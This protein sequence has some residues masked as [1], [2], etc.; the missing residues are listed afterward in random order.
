MLNRIVLTGRLTRDPELRRTT[1]DTAVA[2]FTIAVD[3]T[4]KDANGEKTTTF[5]GVTVWDKQADNVAKF[6]RKGALVGVDGRIRQRTYLRKDGTKASVIE[7]IANHVEFLEPKGSR[8][9][10]NEEIIFDDEPAVPVEESKN[11]DSI[12]VTDDD[13][14]F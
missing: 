12:D 7:V 5:I 6:L 14:P 8:E 4:M 3:D 2:S 1:G 11:L 13:L 10:P 9:I